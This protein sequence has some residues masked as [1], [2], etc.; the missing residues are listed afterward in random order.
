MYKLYR[1]CTNR[2]VPQRQK[3]IYSLVRV[4]FPDPR[5]GIIMFSAL[6][7]AVESCHVFFMSCSLVSFMLQRS[8]ANVSPLREREIQFFASQAHVW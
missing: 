2:P 3:Q 8:R 4:F 1:L 5:R 6:P 7:N